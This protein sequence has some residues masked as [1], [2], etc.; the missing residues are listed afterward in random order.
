MHNPYKPIIKEKTKR[1]GE[2]REEPRRRRTTNVV[3]TKRC[4]EQRTV[5]NPYKPIIKEKTKRCGERRSTKKKKNYKCS[6][7]KEVWRT[8]NHACKE[9]HNYC[10][11]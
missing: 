2:R 6:K 11:D 1:C 5:H 4:G 9:I 10:K 8:E 3:K 7:D